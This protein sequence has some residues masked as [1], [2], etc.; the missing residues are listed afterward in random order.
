MTTLTVDGYSVAMSPGM[1]AAGFSAPGAD[2][3]AEPF[4]DDAAATSSPGAAP[5]P[6]ASVSPGES[7]AA[8]ADIALDSLPGFSRSGPS[9]LSA[10]PALSNSAGAPAPVPVA[11]KSGSFSRFA[12]MAPLGGAA[13]SS[14]GGATHSI[15]TNVMAL[16]AYRYNVGAEQILH[17]SLQRL[18]SGKR[19]NSAADDSSGLALVEGLKTQ[20]LGNRQ[21]IKN[22]QD[23]ISLTQT[24]EGVLGTVHD[25]LQRMRELA[26]KGA[27]DTYSLSARVQIGSEMDAIRV[28]IG[29]ISQAT[30]AMGRKILGGKYVEPADALRFQIG[31]NASDAEVIAITFVD[32]TDIAKN[33]IGH[34]PQD[35]NHEA[36]QRSI[37]NIDDQIQVISGARASLGALLNRFEHTINHLNVS[38]EN[39]CA[40]Q[41]R[42]QDADMAAETV[43]YMRGRILSQSSSAVLSQALSAPRGVLTLLSA[44]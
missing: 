1:S 44:A 21:A 43:N 28:E 2:D 37:E 7:S 17:Q 34:I 22:A 35:A 20:V 16:N 23:G 24:A 13:R 4:S 8:A 29:R 32:V 6:G 39:L 10:S 5:S 33:Q 26:V 42:M 27:N 9:G 14:G 36:F 41:S 40:A 12:V 3:S 31:A 25:M 15:T 19:I 11:S 38:V 18:S 30:E